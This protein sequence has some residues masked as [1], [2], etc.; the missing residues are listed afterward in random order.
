MRIENMTTRQLKLAQSW[1]ASRAAGSVKLPST[2]SSRIFSVPHSMTRNDGSLV[3]SNT[4][5]RP[6]VHKQPVASRPSQSAVSTPW[7]NKRQAAPTT[8]AD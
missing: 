2:T 6:K 8:T 7:N 4:L 3:S 5:Y 1:A